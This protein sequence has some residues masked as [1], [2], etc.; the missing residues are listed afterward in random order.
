MVAGLLAGAANATGVVSDA[1]FL[2]AAD[3]SAPALTLDPF[4]SSLVGMVRVTVGRDGAV[5]LITSLEN[6]AMLTVTLAAE[7]GF[8]L[9]GLMPAGAPA[10]GGQ[11][12]SQNLSRPSDGSRQF[13]TSGL[14]MPEAAM[15]AGLSAW[16]GRG[17]VVLAGAAN[18]PAGVIQPAVARTKAVTLPL[19][20]NEFYDSAS[21]AVYAM[22]DGAPPWWAL[23]GVLGVVFGWAAGRKERLDQKRFYSENKNRKSSSVR[24]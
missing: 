13:D 17:S 15:N 16:E 12:L 4:N 19:A 23:P 8:P 7:S 2:R 10:A 24:L 20:V 1:S 5:Q 21:Q 22:P 3:L 14:P 6:K 11:E 9:A 18:V